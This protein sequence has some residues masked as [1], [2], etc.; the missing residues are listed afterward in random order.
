MASVPGR[1]VQV[2][3]KKIRGQVEEVDR[4]SVEAILGALQGHRI[5]NHSKDSELWRC[6]NR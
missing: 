2:D 5:K 6:V 1:M 3:E 4:S